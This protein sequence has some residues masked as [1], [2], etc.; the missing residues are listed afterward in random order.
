MEQVRPR[1]SVE[2]ASLEIHVSQ[3]TVWRILR[4]RLRFKPY[5]LQVLWAGD[6]RQHEE[7]CIEMQDKL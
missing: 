2:K 5:K 7:F 6:K 1:K 3:T 4:K